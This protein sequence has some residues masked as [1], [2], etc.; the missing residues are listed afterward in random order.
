[1]GAFLVA[2]CAQH[3]EVFYR[4]SYF[5]VAW[6][7]LGAKRQEH[8]F[9][10]E[11]VARFRPAPNREAPGLLSLSALLGALGNEIDQAQLEVACIVEEAEGFVVTGSSGGRYEYRYYRYLDLRRGEASPQA[12]L[13]RLGLATE[14]KPG[15]APPNQHNS[16]LRHRLH[17]IP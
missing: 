16:P 10:L 1:L 12:S 15:F 13:N 7:P 17:L 2:E 11:D 4:D 6:E 8:V 14:M 9:S 5:T 3:V